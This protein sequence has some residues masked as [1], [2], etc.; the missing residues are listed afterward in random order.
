M[1]A[2]KS[3]QFPISGLVEKV[4]F[5]LKKS[6]ESPTNRIAELWPRLA[7]PKISKHTKPINLRNKKLFVRVDDSSWAF[8]LNTRYKTGLLKR[9]Q[10]ALG[11]GIVS[12]I[13]FK[14]GEI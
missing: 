3:G 1:E 9:V 11:E 7:G 6:Q 13:Y 2:K 8:E 14:V 4:L 10:N 12:E 5:D